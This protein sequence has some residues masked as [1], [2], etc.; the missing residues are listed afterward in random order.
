MSQKLTINVLGPLEVLTPKEHVFLRNRRL[1]TL[2][3]ALAL[4]PGESV[5]MEDLTKT[6]WP[7]NP[8]STAAH[9]IRKAL[10]GLRELL[11]HGWEAIRT[12][13]TGY[14][15]L[16]DPDQSDHLRFR[17]L[18][19]RAQAESPRGPERV[20]ALV[21]ALRLWRGV[22]AKGDLRPDSR[23]VTDAL[24]EGREVLAD[25]VATMSGLG[26]EQEALQLIAKHATV[27]GGDET[28]Q[29]LLRQ[30]RRGPA[31]EPKRP[32]RRL[33]QVYGP[34]AEPFP[35]A[36][37]PVPDLGTRTGRSTLL[38]RDRLFSGR[39]GELA[40]ITRHLT[41][42]G[43]SAAPVVLVHGPVGVGKSAL[44]VEAAHRALSHYPTGAF[45]LNAENTTGRRLTEAGAVTQLLLQMDGMLQR[46]P[47]DPAVRVALWRGVVSDQASLV[48]IDNYEG[49]FDLRQIL[50]GEARCAAII[51]S[52][53][54][55]LGMSPSLHC[56]LDP[57]DE[58]E[59]QVLAERM[60]G[61]RGPG[62]GRLGD[63]LDSTHGMPSLIRGACEGIRMLGLD[64]SHRAIIRARAAGRP[65]LPGGYD[66]CGRIAAAVGSLNDESRQFLAMLSLAPAPEYT[67][68]L[69]VTLSGRTPPKAGELIM[70]LAGRSLVTAVGIDTLVIPYA[71]HSYLREKRGELASA[72]QLAAGAD[73][74]R[75]F[76][77]AAHGIRKGA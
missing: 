57:M 63:V 6:I 21:A 49:D 7:Q 37:V 56:R 30:V 25:T 1:R 26:R 22:P 47:A 2:L 66:L 59:G 55:V 12:T 62:T 74:Y 67:Y 31:P 16:L 61:T 48:V 8:P 65:V 13:S 52:Q 15:L 10:S 73:R 4:A 41:A 45:Y 60:L 39:D 36:P 20:D 68:D 29:S 46:L 17:T 24:A 51:T 72:S 23:F 64:R 14:T 75:A 53:S 11:P 50:P 43:R 71:V 34:A 27:L 5:E 42:E 38:S 19:A 18:A 70:N 33:F 35:P 28:L 40:E 54:P 32:S 44:A 3:A 76:V 58:Q 9:Q 69:M 77:G